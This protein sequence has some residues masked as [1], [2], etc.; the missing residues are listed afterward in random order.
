MLYDTLRR[1][2]E[3]FE[4]S[5]DVKLYV[6]GVTPYDTTHVGHARTYMVF[7]VLV[8]N[9]RSRAHRVNY[10]QNITDVDDSILQRADELGVPFDE[11]GKRYTEIY[12]N[13]M[14]ELNVRAA[15]LYPAA[16]EAIPDM[17][18]MI[19]RLLAS[20]HAYLLANGDVYFRVSSAPNFGE[21]SRLSRGEMCRAEA[22]QDGSTIDDPRKE[23]PL[24]FPLWRAARP[25]EPRW[26]SPWGEGRPG[27]HIECSAMAL[28]RLGARL[29]IHGGGDDLVYPHHECE[30][31]QS[32]AFTGERPFARFWVHVAMVRL[33]GEKMSKSLGN[34][35][36]VREL[37]E[38]FSPDGLRLYLLGCH[39]R[40][41]LDYEER[42]LQEADALARRLASSASAEASESGSE[43]PLHELTQRFYAALDDDLDTPS[44]IAVLAELA[45]VVAHDGR[46]GLE[47]RRT[48]VE[49]GKKLGLRLRGA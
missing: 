7:D 10:V 18:R 8:R 47:G 16:T 24:D 14:A 20:R 43:Q 41:P 11:L 40:M 36:F 42:E 31:A 1:T 49:L 33:G 13:D 17:Q 5:E 15:D 30:I 39:Y 25:R 37:L 9:L 4:A 26:A 44:A 22:S 29:D 23:D 48:L 12:M 34:L 2:K 46:S 45:D 38:R 27:W 28:A 35:V 32:E 6:C 3:A 21:L 19:E